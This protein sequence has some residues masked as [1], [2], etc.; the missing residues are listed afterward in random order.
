MKHTVLPQWLDNYIYNDEGAVYNPRPADVVL[1]ADQPFEFIQLYLGTYFPRSY[2]EAYCIINS[3]LDNPSYLRSMESKEELYILDICCGTGGEIIGAVCALCSRLPNL[4]RVYI[5]SYD[6]SEKA[7]RFLYHATRQLNETVSADVFITPNQFYIETEQDFRDLMSITSRTYDFVMCFKA[8]NEFVQK[9]IF[10]EPYKFITESM[11]PKLSYNGLFILADVTTPIS[12]TDKR[13][14]PQIMN[15]QINN[16]LQGVIGFTTL[17]PYPC[18]TYEDR[19]GGCYMQDIFYVSHSKKQRD[20]SKLAYRIIS[21]SD[22][23]QSITLPCQI[24][25]RYNTPG[26][27]KHMPY[28]QFN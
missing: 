23:A 25:C 13:F 22:F 16:L 9:N 6:A 21:R 3:L 11:L 19:C 28:N 2:S 7:V 26:A 15:A 5:E 12:Q 27:D 10:D 17:V 24:Q 14:Y 18:H 8:I 4:R 1:N 20:T